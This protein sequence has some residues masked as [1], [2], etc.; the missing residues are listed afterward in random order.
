MESDTMRHDVLVYDSDEDYQQQLVPFLEAGLDAGEALVAVPG[1]ATEP[2]LRGALGAAS[3]RVQFHRC[4]DW[5]TR[6]EAALAGYDAVV[7]GALRDGATGVRV[8]AELPFCSSQGE[9]DSWVRYEAIINR[10]FAE[11]PVS[12]MCT[13]D[14]RVLPG[15]VLDAMRHTHSHVVSDG[16]QESPDYQDPAEVV[17]RFA[18]APEAPPELHHV[19]VDGAH[20][21]RVALSRALADAGVAADQAEA[22]ILAVSEVVVNAERHGGGVRTLRVGG[23]EGVFVCEVSDAG[24]GLDDPLAGYLPP[25][26]RGAHGGGLWVARQLTRRLDLVSSPEGGLTVRLWA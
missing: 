16:R 19:A 5:Y 11:R 7:R 1:R 9:W 14:S 23:G 20:E 25:G 26:A 13:C 18:A 17:Q 3:E 12:I 4:E 8:A 2:L 10:A 21:L 24:R 22:M 15:H 6:P